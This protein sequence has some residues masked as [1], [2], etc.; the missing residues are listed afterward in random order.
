MRDVSIIGIGQ[1]KVA[2]HWDRS[3]RHLAAD[4]VLAAM[5]DA[6][7]E[8]T[9]M[10][11]LYVGN[12]LS[13]LL[14]GQEHLGALIADF[15]GLRGI[16]AVKVE[17]A[18]GSGAA[19]LRLGYAAVAGGLHDFVVVMGVE[20]MTDTVNAET[21]TGLAMAAD[22]D[23]ES[24]H[25]LTFV[26]VNALLMRRYMHEHGV[27]HEDFA[28]FAVNA[29]LNAGGNPHAMY[30]N[31]ITAEQFARARMIADPINLL[32]S[33]G[34]GDGAAAVVLCPTHLAR[35]YSN[36][37][38]VRIR[39]SSMATDAVAVHDRSDPLWLSA[40]EA[41]AFKAYQQARVGPRDIDLFEV[42]DAFTIMSTLSLE[43]SGFAERGKGVWLAKAG[44][45]GLE[46]RIPI[47]TMGGLKARGHP[48]GATGVYQVVEVAQQ[49][50]G[51]AGSNQI[52][53]ARWGM[54][55]N[56]GGS[57]ATVITHIL[58]AGD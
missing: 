32:D 41:S 12:M 48:V 16:E 6:G 3:L 19:A 23:Y 44:E 50:R 18:C 33:S 20:K 29:H 7:V 17:A 38:A 40:V 51:E 11:A 2:E 14:T 37:R 28:G 4:A 42:H 49:L 5:E 43:A 1:T 56:I 26:S 36:G 45:I 35:E 55:Q 22:A 21:T 8:P 58:E 24:I 47:S 39:A 15:V 30:R 9:A 34:I 13:G 52:A 31:K 53:D 25:G 10:D 27:E 57:G 54:A 46:G